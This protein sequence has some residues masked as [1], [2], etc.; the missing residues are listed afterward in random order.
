MIRALTGF[1]TRHAWKVIALWAVLGIGL[2]V[3]GPMLLSR[4]TQA[5]SAD[6]LPDSYDSAAALRIAEQEFGVRPDATTVT[7]LVARADGRPLSAA[8][9]QR[10]EA[11]A[12]KLGRHRV[13][14]P[15]K[16]DQPAFLVPDH[17]QTPRIAPAMV[18]PDRGFELLAVELTGSAAEPGV[19]DV[20]R[21]F[22][23]SARAQFADAGMRTGFT[24]GTAEAV[25]TA[26][27]H[28]TATT[29]GGAL[30]V[31][32]IVL[33][34]V[35]V[36]RSVLAAVLPL[37]AVAMISGAAGGAVAGAAMLTGLRLDP[38][39]PGLISV[40]LLGIGID[41]LLFLLFRFREHLRARPDQPAR[42]AAA[43]VSGRV[44][45]AITS[46][47]LTIVAAFATLGVAS[48]GQ[49]RS[50]GP[51]I[52]VAVLVMLLG[53]LTLMPA[54]LAACGRGMFWPSRSLHRPPRE[55]FAARFGLLVARRPLP[56]LLASVAALAALAA[57]MTGI[58]MD[59][60]QGGASG[61][62]AAATATEI[63]RAL[64][65]GVWDPTTVY[66]TAEDGTP[67]TTARLD[68]LAQA[69]GK[70]DGIGRVGPTVLNDD[71]R[72]A[73][74]DLYP[75]ADPQSRQARDLAAGPVRAAVAAHTPAGTSA[76]VGGTAAVFADISTA[77][78]HDLAVVFPVAAALIGL[79][80]LLLLRSVLAPVVLML[81]V[82][83]GFAATLGA[84]TLLFQHLLDGPGVSFTLPL[85]L[86]LFVVALG[87]DYNILVT[88]RIRE[89]MRH[90]GTA[91]TAIARAVR[92]SAP[93]VA[94]AGLVLAGSFA[95]L[96]TTPGTEQV[97]FAMTLG[98]LLSALVL[99]LV[100]VPALAALLGRA[101]WWPLR[102]A[103]RRHTASAPEPAPEPATLPVP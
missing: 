69:L 90:P 38:G 1:S 61:T 47:A 8:D 45:T 67:L 101:L 43:E 55:G 96:A 99:S 77:V 102:P 83:L 42:A 16:K 57:G 54:L 18:A 23:D 25:D 71:H 32:L 100:L 41:Y 22:R 30:V 13:V 10:I 34:N 15:R 95:T 64:P 73:R 62:P 5:Q 17:S 36:F 35:L 79:I 31:G 87:T 7:V 80:L 91:R 21:T 19:Q 60:G 3:L 76:H 44:G 39:T 48:F 37:L 40:V 4:V 33:L 86:F 66:L 6:F 63:S 81:S 74:I 52:A 49:F 92:H 70:V 82:G 56:L 9:Q 53:S 58:R 50:L 89:E 72:A 68:G 65:A 84:A 78:D 103:H 97:A 11:E 85:V 59:Y 14:M 26:D 24:G 20:Y 88:D 29:V 93:A 27:A 28:R 2:G 98:I 75:T 51:A 94:T 46:A 12:A